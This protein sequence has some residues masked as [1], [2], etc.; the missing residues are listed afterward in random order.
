MADFTP[1]LYPDAAEAQQLFRS[2]QT[3]DSVI[4]HGVAVSRCA[5]ELAQ[6][7]SGPVDT[8]LLSAA[9]LLH[10]LC[11]T[12]A[13]HAHAGAEILQQAGY[14]AL[15]EL[16]AVHHDL[17]EDAGVE[18]CLLYLADKLVRGEQRISLEER[19]F[20][21]RQKC[22]TPEALAAWQSRYDRALQIIQKYQF[23]LSD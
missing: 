17:P 3:P 19:F 2:C 16:V 13:D 10:D 4:A 14:S 11:R 9:C 7:I 22:R 1:K 12:E 20:S 15:A 18:S 21:S 6:Q 5:A 8:A 23:S